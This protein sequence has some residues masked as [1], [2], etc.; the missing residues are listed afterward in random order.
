M[1][2]SD[3][4]KHPRPSLLQQQLLSEVPLEQLLVCHECD[5]L[6]QRQPIPLERRVICPRCGFEL[7]SN[8]HA[9]RTRSL[10]L[11]LTALLL[12]IPANFLPIMQLQLLG[13][14]SSDTVW[15]AVLA[16]H[17]SG[18]SVI[19]VVVLLSSMLIP[20]AKLLCQL[21]VL[22]IIPLRRLRPLGRR[23][24]RWYHHL[25]EWGMLEVYLMGILVSVVK[26]KD[27]ADLSFGPGLY[28]F[29]GLLLSQLWLEVVM[30]PQQ[31]WQAL[32]DDDA[33]P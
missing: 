27:M 13:Q 3:S 23:L 14:R 29:I 22:L 10:A 16:L 2:M 21:L 8:R 15:S 30:S 11:V 1:P 33:R 4:A 20:L 9:V 19:A 24:Y 5:L 7:Q 32:E 17:D 12:F 25:Q 18:M 28:C 26:L 6:M 31:I